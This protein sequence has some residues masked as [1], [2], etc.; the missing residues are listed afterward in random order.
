MRKLLSLTL[1]YG[2]LGVLYGSL[3]TFIPEEF[4][5][6][7]HPIANAIVI[8]GTVALSVGWSYKI[9]MKMHTP[10]LKFW[11]IITLGLVGVFAGAY[12]PL[13]YPIFF[14]ALI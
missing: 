2:W 14:L 10:S 7:L 4:G 12:A 13:L 9:E 3:F 1:T 5:Y 8:L 11:M 6:T